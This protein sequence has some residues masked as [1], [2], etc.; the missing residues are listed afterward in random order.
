M[1]LLGL[2]SE[3]GLVEAMVQSE[4]TG[5]DGISAGCCLETAGS[6]VIEM[7]GMSLTGGTICWPCVSLAAM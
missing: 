3:A 7:R 5:R 2:S 1:G 4:P 6:A